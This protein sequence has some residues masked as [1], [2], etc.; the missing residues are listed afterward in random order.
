MPSNTFPLSLAPTGM[1]PRRNDSP[2]VP[3]TPQEITDQ[4]LECAEVGVT[5]VHLH[6]RDVNGDPAWRKEYFAEIIR[7]IRA[8][9]PD[10]VICVTTSGRSVSDVKKRSDVLDLDG[11]LRPDMASLTLSSMNFA[12]SASVNSPETVQYLAG[13]MLERGIVPELEVFDSGML[14][15]LSYLIHKGFLKPPFVVNLILGGI[16]TAQAHPLELGLLL[17]RVPEGCLWSVGGIGRA[18]LPANLLG[19]AAGGGV[20]VGLEDNLH[21]DDARTALATNKE[22][23]QRVVSI[24]GLMGKQVMS[25]VEF[26]RQVLG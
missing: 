25:P 8:T 5:S 24:A 1:V 15:Y 16:A 11:D 26:R 3:L 20:R 10:V 7:L 9:R 12:Q 6:A 2:H 18:Q 14:N 19:L 21:L 13:A 22:L 17:E 4:V 23:V